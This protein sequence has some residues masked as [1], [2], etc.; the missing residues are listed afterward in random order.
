[1]TTAAGYVRV[2]TE[3]QARE[4]YGMAA[5]EQAARAYCQAHG[6]ELV[7]VYADAGRSGKSM[8]GREALARLLE[9]ARDGRFQRVVFWKLDRLGRNLRDILDICDT[10]ESLNVGIVSIQEA[11]DTGMAAGRMVRSFLGAVPEF[12]REVIAE[13]I[14]VGIAEVARQ[15]GCEGPR[16][17]YVSKRKTARVHA[18]PT[19]S[20]ACLGSRPLTVACFPCPEP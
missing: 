12:E 10:L 9:D 15:E 3:E 4:G 18:A 17:W 7:E 8:R 16:S 2:S 20:R 11:I 14:K 19:A 1:M 13:R 6:W 5:Q